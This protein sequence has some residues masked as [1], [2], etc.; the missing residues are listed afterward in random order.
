MYKDDIKKIGDL[1]KIVY[2]VLQT[3][4]EGTKCGGI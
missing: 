1:E 4:T 3:P 2:K